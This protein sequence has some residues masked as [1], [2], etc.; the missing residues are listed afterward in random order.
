MPGDD[1]LR[2]PSRDEANHSPGISSSLP[3]GPALRRWCHGDR[4]LICS[5][6]P[7]SE[8]GGEVGKYSICDARA[9]A[10]DRVRLCHPTSHANADTD[11]I[12]YAD[13][14]TDPQTNA[15]ADA[16]ADAA[17]DSEADPTADGPR[18]QDGES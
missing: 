15:Q 3:A 7:R 14:Q 4:V 17:S 5:G 9:Y 12:R 16:E 11:R 18:N 2:R 13:P 6:C 1:G 8:F 10:A